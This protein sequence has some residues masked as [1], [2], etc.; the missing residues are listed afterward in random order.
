M[1]IKDWQRT[2]DKRS[3]K[4]AT[5]VPDANSA[6]PVLARLDVLEAELAAIAARPLQD[7]GNPAEKSNS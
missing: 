4:S 2:K 3:S 7:E 5:P 1:N 6:Q